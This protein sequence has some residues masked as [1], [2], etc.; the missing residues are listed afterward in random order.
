MPSLI[1]KKSNGIFL[2]QR[3][4]TGRTLAGLEAYF[5]EA[6]DSRLFGRR[7][8]RIFAALLEP[9]LVLPHID[10][11]FLTRQVEEDNIASNAALFQCAAAVEVAVDEQRFQGKP[12]NTMR[13]YLSGEFGK[14]SWPW[15]AHPVIWKRFFLKHYAEELLVLKEGA[16]K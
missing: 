8:A 6:V 9:D 2:P 1:E 16:E 3:L 7:M 13:S 5:E 12:E 14:R 15:P 4:D 11:D 10:D